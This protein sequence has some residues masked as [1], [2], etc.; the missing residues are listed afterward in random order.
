MAIVSAVL[1]GAPV[2]QKDATAV[3]TG[4]LPAAWPTG[5]H[6]PEPD[7]QTHEYNA[8]LYILRQSGCTNFEKPFLYLL[9][10]R[11][12]A[13]LVDSGAKGADVATAVSDARRRW[14]AAHSGR[15]LPLIVA[16]SHGHGDHTAGD[17][18]LAVT[19][20]TT[21]VP[22][23]PE[24]VQRFF[25]LGD[26]P[27]GAGTYDLGE[28]MLDI[29]PIPGHEGASIAI[30]DRRTGLLLTGDTLYPGRLYVRDSAAFIASV[31]RLVEFSR[32]KVVMHVLG[33]HIENMRTP[34]LD[35]PE[36]TTS[37]PDEHV[38]ELGRAQLLELQ[39]GLRSMHGAIVRRAFRDFTIWPVN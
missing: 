8:D 19:P 36:G 1:A 3:E 9:F 22:G 7:F 27:T 26:W 17:T 10:G 29:I 16:H 25:A 35:Y 39:D 4:R 2:Q 24:A 30:Y 32:D 33:A 20:Q 37:Q 11:D 14:S 34:Y 28:R 12:R 6:C 5:A 23:T 38:L 21:V 31:D 15:K 18:A 13:L